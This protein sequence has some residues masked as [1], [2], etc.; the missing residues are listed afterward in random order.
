MHCAR[1]PAR[2]WA[3]CSTQPLYIYNLNPPALNPG[4]PPSQVRALA[5]VV[6]V[7]PRLGSL[8]HTVATML[9]EIVAFAFPYIVVLSGF[10]TL[11]CGE[12][13]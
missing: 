6:P 1:V 10:A 11:L 8:L 9:G 3:C 12:L 5:I 13:V 7:Y 2:D 4:T